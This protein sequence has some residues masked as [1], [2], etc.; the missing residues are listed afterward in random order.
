[1]ISQVGLGPLSVAAFTL[2]Q[3]VVVQHMHRKRSVHE[4]CDAANRLRASRRLLQ[5]RRPTGRRRAALRLSLILLSLGLRRV[6]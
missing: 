5:T 1:M 2:N 4:R 3:S 6:K